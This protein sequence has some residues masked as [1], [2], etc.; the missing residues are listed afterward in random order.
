MTIVISGSLA[1]TE[2]YLSAAWKPVILWH[3]VVT[4]SG[5]LADSEATNYPVGNLAN[6]STVLKW[7]SASTG[8]QYLYANYSSE[9]PIDAVGVAAH[10]WGSGGVA[11]T[12]ET[13]AGDEDA[14]WEVAVPEQ[15]FAN[16]SPH[17]FQFTERHCI[18]VRLKLVPGNVDPVYPEAAIL[19][20]G[21]LITVDSGLPP[22]HAPISFSDNRETVDNQAQDGGYLGSVVLNESHSTS[23]QFADLDPTWYR[24]Y[25]EPFRKAGKGTTFFFAWA[26]QA[27]PDEVGYCWITNDPRAVVNRTTGEVAFS[28]QIG[29]VV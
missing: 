9:N 23:V 11:V 5:L 29:A 26:P 10:N 2:S 19:F 13:L 14:E 6:P 28:M 25:L 15:T 12:V 20:V 17:V 3:N 18:G 22:G 1:L 21:R 8:Q 4:V 24:Q 7:R 27:W 16:D